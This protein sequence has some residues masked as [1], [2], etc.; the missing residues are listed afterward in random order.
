MTAYL[1]VKNNFDNLS[2]ENIFIQHEKFKSFDKK[3]KQ[4]LKSGVIQ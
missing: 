4:N 1:S 2:Q 3:I